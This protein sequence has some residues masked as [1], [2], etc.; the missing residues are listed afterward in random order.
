MTMYHKI[1]IEVDVDKESSN[2]TEKIMKI[3]NK[4]IE[5]DIVKNVT[6]CQY[7]VS[8]EFVKQGIDMK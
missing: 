1:W 3:I 2:K 7:I 6:K 8:G 5:L 4:L